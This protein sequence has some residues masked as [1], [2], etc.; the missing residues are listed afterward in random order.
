MGQLEEH[1][2]RSRLAGRHDAQTYAELVDHGWTPRDVRLAILRASHESPALGAAPSGTVVAGG[3]AT[4]APGWS[5]ALLPVAAL[6]AA[7]P[8][9]AVSV[10]AIPM[11]LAVAVVLAGG[12]APW[13]TSTVTTLYSVVG[14]LPW[15]M[16][17]YVASLA[18]L[19][20]HVA[21]R[22]ARDRWGRRP[23]RPRSTS[24]LAGLT[25]GMLV[26]APVLAIGGF[27]LFVMVAMICGQ[28]PGICR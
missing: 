13:T 25:T 5:R 16:L 7:V 3:A 8:T 18:L 17:C 10:V 20:V 28:T 2:L 23:P 19:L 24:V 21:R 11:L 15:L 6:L 12:P 1:V 26:T 22:P 14:A 27:G 9:V 4:P